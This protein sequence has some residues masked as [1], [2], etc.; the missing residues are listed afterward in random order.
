MSYGFR[1]KLTQDLKKLQK[2]K[3]NKTFQKTKNVQVFTLKLENRMISV[4]IQIELEIDTSISQV[5]KLEIFVL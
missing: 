1:L 3:T 2:T 4:I 5:V